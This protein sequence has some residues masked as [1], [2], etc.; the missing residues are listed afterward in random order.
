M[1]AKNL[2]PGT[3]VA[4]IES[5][6]A[7]MGGVVL[8]SVIIV[9]RPKVI[10]EIVFESREGAENVVET[11]N[12]Q[13]VSLLAHHPQ[14]SRTNKLSQADGNIL[15]VYHKQ[16]AISS[17]HKLPASTSQNNNNN[18][19]DRNIDTRS[20]RDEIIDGSQ[21]FE[22]RMD[23]DDNDNRG[24]LYSDNL[25]NNRGRGRGNSRE[26]G[27]GGGKDRGRGYR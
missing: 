25:V 14:Q 1:V 8:S 22:D 27:R 9:E 21:G 2:A 18:N 13:N 24:G 20:R 10:A 15:H 23:T 4:D 12:N 7:P 3:T 16:G 6:M 26:R 5:A 17:A 19:R 11:F